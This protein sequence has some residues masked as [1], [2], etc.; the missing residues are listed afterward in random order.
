MDRIG[1]GGGCHW[2]TE[3]VFQFV[4]GVEKV[5]QGWIAS[6]PPHDLFS[7]AVIVHFNP[8]QVTLAH[9]V[10]IHLKTHS[11]TSEHSMRKKYRSAVYVFNEEQI[12]LT[13]ESLIEEQKN[14]SEKI[15]TQIL[16]FV[17]FK[18]N[19]ELYQNYYKKNPAKE[20]CVRYI[21]P[22]LAIV[23]LE[24]QLQKK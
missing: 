24:N 9:L 3:A 12:K 4:S 23:K 5:D 15:L 13:E 10:S 2:C 19:K 22:K 6:T 11:C 1:F 17:E 18:E 7:E 21:E 8:K 16:P 14:F 20:F